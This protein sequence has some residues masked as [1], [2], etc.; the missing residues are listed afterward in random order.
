MLAVG[1]VGA[2]Q[3]VA[4]VKVDGDDAGLA[5]VGE[6]GQRGLLDRA[7]RRRHED[8]VIF[9]E[10][11]DRQHHRDLLAVSQREHVHDR[12][13][14]G[15]ARALRH[16]PD[17]Q[18]V[19]AAAVREAQQEVVRIGDEQLVDPVVFLHRRG[20]LAASAALLRTVLGQGLAL[21]VAAVRQGHDHVGGR[22][23][24]FGVELGRVHLDFRT[25]RVLRA[26]RE[27]G[28][29]GLQ[30]FADDGRDAL[31][32]GQDIEQVGDGGH[33]VLVFADDLV[34][35]QPGQAL[36]AHVQDFLGL[37]VAQAVHA[38]ALEAE[39]DAQVV[40]T[41][42]RAAPR[43]V[44][45][46]AREHFA[47]QR[48]IPRL[49]HQFLAGHRRRR[50]RLDDRDE[51]IDVGQRH[52]Q[53]FQ[54]VAALAGLAQLEYRA[55]RDHFPAMLQEV[56]DHLL[57]VEQAGLA[58]DQRHQVHPEGVLKLRILVEIVQDNL[59]DLA[60]L[61][62]DDQAHAVLVGLVPDIGDAFDL[63]VV[64]QFGNAFLQR[65]LVD[66]VGN[67]VDHD[68]LAIALLHVLEVGLGAHDDAAAARAIAFA[69]AGHAVND[70]AGGEIG[71]R[72][73]LDQL[74]DRAGRIAQ[75]VQAAVDHFLE[76]V[77]RD[78]G[79]HAHRDARA[80][81]DQQVGQARRQQQR[82]LF[83]AVVVGA[84]VHRLLVDVGQEFMGDLGQADFGVAHRRGVVAVDRAEVAL[85]VDQH[86]AHGEILRHADDGVINGLVA[87]G[88]VLT[89]D[90]P[91]DTRGLLVR[92][93]PVVV[94]FVHR[95]EHA[96]VDRLEPVPHIR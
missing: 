41:E 10:F 86:V 15:I 4:V 63:L 28:L 13:A 72:D 96:P 47:H 43:R 17:L 46:G 53:A 95:V 82:F 78:V 35:L 19:H 21:D 76:V 93:V 9:A 36:Q 80:A 5:R 68:R 59:W 45:I 38:V 40:G 33:D 75:A 57:Q 94:Q 11:L 70:A 14:A 61:E 3:V 18:P 16:F 66:L 26:G 62:L 92:T 39:L 60:A 1:Q 32:A 22:D 20:L 50:R 74:I 65:L 52:R 79:G 27:F 83:A 73:E 29:D 69:H 89:D 30:L 42:G 37:R 24:V 58:V 56:V 71:R 2:D 91:D 85:A 7:A 87:V 34:L 23:Q 8:V 12:L 88:V 51:I 64:D 77:R 49:R 81:V 54:H 25:A 48:R 67:R 90:V 44:A 6:I 55:A 31:G 84:E